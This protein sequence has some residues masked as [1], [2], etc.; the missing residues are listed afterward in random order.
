MLHQSILDI[1][2]EF[3]IDSNCFLQVNEYLWLFD[4]DETAIDVGIQL[5]VQ[6]YDQVGQP[7][8]VGM[9]RI[10]LP[11]HISGL[12]V[13]HSSFEVK[14]LHVSY[15]DVL[16][17][18]GHLVGEVAEQLAALQQGLVEHLDCPVVLF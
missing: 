15:T 10:V 11:D 8:E 12:K 13:T 1:G 9:H 4:V 7:V 3:L 18:L 17:H 14:L 5:L 16:V 2:V 6:E